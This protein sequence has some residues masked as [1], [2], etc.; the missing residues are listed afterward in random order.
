[1]SSNG[2]IHEEETTSSSTLSYIDVEDYSS[3]DDSCFMFEEI[4]LNDDNDSCGVRSSI[5]SLS[6]SMVSDDDGS[7]TSCCSENYDNRSNTEKIKCALSGGA[8]MMVGALLTPTPVP[9]GIPLVGAGLH[10]L[11]REFDGAKSAERQF[12]AAVDHVKSKLS[13]PQSSPTEIDV[14]DF[15]DPKYFSEQGKLVHQAMLKRQQQRQA[16]DDNSDDIDSCSS[17]EKDVEIRDDT[18]SHEIVDDNTTNKININNTTPAAENCLPTQ[19][20]FLLEAM[21][22]RS[23]YDTSRTPTAPVVEAKRCCHPTQDIFLVEA[24]ERRS[25]QNKSTFGFLSQVSGVTA[26]KFNFMNAPATVRVF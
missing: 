13:S 4:I 12:I 15:V 21:E 24:I 19:D 16:R 1:L 26:T 5:S 25:R 6:S 9:I 10:V 23:R 7:S 11:G 8:L 2:T 22:R 17:D 18:M 14:G 3:E 20:I